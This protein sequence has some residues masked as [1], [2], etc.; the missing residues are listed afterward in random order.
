VTISDYDSLQ[1]TI[2]HGYASNRREAAK[3]GIIAGLDIEMASTTYLSFLE[4]LIDSKE[5]DLTL[6]DEAVLRILELKRDLG[7]FENPFKGADPEL[8]TKIVLSEENLEKSQECARESIV[9]LKNNGILPLKNTQKIAIIG[10]YANSKKK[11]SDLGH[12]MAYAIFMKQS[13]KYLKIK[14]FLLV[15]LQTKMN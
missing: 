4:E 6:L 13:P 10:P 5:V 2:A 14:L 1:Q 7:L 8:E 9:L 3:K 15:L 11:Q 12:G